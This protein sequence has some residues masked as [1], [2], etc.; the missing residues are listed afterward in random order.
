MFKKDPVFLFVIFF[1]I[2]FSIFILFSVSPT[3][4]PTYFIYIILGLLAF[5]FFSQTDYSILA[6]FS[7]HFYAISIFLLVVTLIIGQV[8][9]GTIRWIP[10]GG[11]TFQP[12][13]IVRPF[14]LIFFANYLTQKELTLRRLLKAFILLG[15]PFL[16]ILIQP[17]LG[18][19]ILTFFGFLGVLLASG[20]N[21]RFIVL[22][23][24]IAALLTPIG[25]QFLADYQKERVSAFVQPGQDPLGTGYNSIQSMIAAG[26]G[27]LFG[28][29]LGKGVQTQLAFLPEKQTDF[30]FAAIAEE[31]G[32]FGA[33][34]VLCA[35]FILFLLMLRIM[36]K[37]SSFGARAFTAGFYVTLLIQ[38]FIHIGMN[39][40][41]LPI[42]GIPLPLVS[43]GGSSF[44]ATMIGLGM[45][46][47]TG[48]RTSA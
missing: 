14:L 45:V 22:S 20:V 18:V 7:T 15:I 17:S 37:A 33:G 48:R 32:F 42:T 12:S 35:L 24:V 31:M 39:L 5:W 3:I 36:D 46:L 34:L 43:A 47:A 6:I 16:L 25:W 41:L 10:I 29:G 9:R 27:K 26:S 19:A 4:F 1:L 21:K 13:E 28:R 38:T 44:L 23:F 8:T 11:L 40:G 30:I 2:L